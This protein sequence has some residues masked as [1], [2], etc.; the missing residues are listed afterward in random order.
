MKKP[1]GFRRL[2]F[3]RKGDKQDAGRESRGLQER[4]FGARGEVV[5][6]GGCIGY[7]SD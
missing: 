4:D 5:A 3:F 2:L 7:A 1:A 6:T